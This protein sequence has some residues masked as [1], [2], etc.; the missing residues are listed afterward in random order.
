MSIDPN[1][2]SNAFDDETR[3]AR[4]VERSQRMGAGRRARRAMP[5]PSMQ[6]GCAGLGHR[7]EASPRSSGC[8]G[9]DGLGDSVILRAG[10]QT[11]EKPILVLLHLDTVI[12]SARRRRTIP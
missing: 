4:M 10:P 2:P 8:R 1:P 5:M 12:R 3:I 11:N 9:R 6:C 7:R